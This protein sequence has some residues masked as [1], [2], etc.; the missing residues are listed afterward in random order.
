MAAME[1][2]TFVLENLVREN[3]KELTPY[4]CARDVSCFLYTQFS[5]LLNLMFYCEGLR[6]WYLARCK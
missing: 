4:R 6:Q 5:L 3:I 1:G 2:K